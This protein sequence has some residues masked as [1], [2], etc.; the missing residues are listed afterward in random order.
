MYSRR[1]SPVSSARDH[2]SN[3]TIVFVDRASSARDCTTTV[4]ELCLC[5][6]SNHILYG[7]WSMLPSSGGEDL[8]MIELKRTGG[9][10]VTHLVNC[11]KHGHLHVA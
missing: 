8:S 3:L 11:P 10:P 5:V 1:G 4:V 7:L 9:M 2:G 6:V